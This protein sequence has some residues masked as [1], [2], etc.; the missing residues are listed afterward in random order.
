MALNSLGCFKH[1]ILVAYIL[2]QCLAFLNDRFSNGTCIHNSPVISTLSTC[3]IPVDEYTAFHS[4]QWSPWSHRPDCNNPI[5]DYS[6]QYCLYTDDTF[7][8]EQGISVLTTAELAASMAD[9]LDDANIPPEFR[10]FL[11]GGMDVAPYRITDIPGRGKSTVATRRIKAWETILIGYP[12]LIT[13]ND[14]EGA[15]Y[16]EIMEMLQRA[17][18]Q[19]RPNARET[20]YS[21]AQSTGDNSI[22]RDV[23]MTNS[24]GLEVGGV[25]HMA[26]FPTTS[27]CFRAKLES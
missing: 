25:K 26:V 22:V 15:S 19:L 10:G 18:D 27:V 5:D 3:P 20:M 17:V 14:M 11:V 7:R 21:L 6:P 16:D 2:G 4:D 24:F 12:A 23:I 9:S 8:G 13:I 1:L